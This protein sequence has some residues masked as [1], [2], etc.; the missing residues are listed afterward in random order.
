MESLE[1]P[2][3]WII[4]ELKDDGGE[5]WRVVRKPDGTFWHVG[6]HRLSAEGRLLLDIGEQ[7]ADGGFLSLLQSYYAQ[8]R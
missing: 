8:R 2:D 7:V 6:S 5:G 4:S 1:L 3:H